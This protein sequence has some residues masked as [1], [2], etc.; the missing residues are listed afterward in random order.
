MFARNWKASRTRCSHVTPT[1]TEFCSY[2]ELVM[3]FVIKAEIA[4]YR[5][6]C[7]SNTMYLKFILTFSLANN[8]TTM[9]HTSGFID[10]L[11]FR[12]S[13]NIVNRRNVDPDSVVDPDFY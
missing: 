7:I 11:A 8:D 9:L 1:L 5:S 12:H 6:A 3:P 4:N 2:H 13:H 10:P